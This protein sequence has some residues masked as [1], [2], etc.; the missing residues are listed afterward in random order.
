MSKG[1]QTKLHRRAFLRGAAGSVMALPFLEAMIGPGRAAADPP[2]PPKRFLV[3]FA[4]MSLGTDRDFFT[5]DGYGAGYD[6]KAGLAPLGEAGVTDAVSVVSGLRM[7]YQTT[8]DVPTAGWNGRWHPEQLVPLLTGIAGGADDAGQDL[9]WRGPTAEQAVGDAIGADTTFR[10]LD[11]RVQPASYRGANVTFAGSQGRISYRRAS[12]GRIDP[13]DPVISPRQAFDALFATFER[14]DPE[15][16]ARRAFEL[17]RRRSVLDLIGRGPR[18]RLLGRLG[19][20]DQRRMERHFDEVRDLEGRIAAIA[21]TVGGACEMLGDPGED[22]AIAGVSAVEDADGNP[23]Y[24]TAQGYSDEERRATVMTDLVRMAFACDLTRAASLM[25]TRE[26]CYMM[27]Q[28]LIGEPYDVH[29]LSHH[30]GPAVKAER[31]GRMLAW[32]VKHFARLVRLLRDTPDGVGGTLLDHS[33][34]L[35][36]TEGGRGFDPG[37]G[38]EGVAHSAENMTILLAGSAGGL[39]P[40]R[41][42]RAPEGRNHPVNVTL[43][44]MEAVGVPG[45]LG[46][47]RGRIDELY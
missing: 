29:A 20:T 28:P 45:G 30:N 21:P 42:V 4:G 14:P 9:T 38:Q 23:I 33:A 39:R 1:S 43:T 31:M 13:V 6:L 44:A 8:G 37:S 27:A 26:Q 5:P 35:F 40:G 17:R 34:L 15:A 16:E 11:Y 32:H 2:L 25:Y 7:P 47:V 18:A 10:T 3:S 24:D 19:T 12:D 22:P 36:L 41:H 46:D